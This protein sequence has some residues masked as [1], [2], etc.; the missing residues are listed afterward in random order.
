MKSLSLLISA[1]SL[2]MATLIA[3]PAFAVTQEEAEEACLSKADEMMIADDKYDDFV[4]ECIVK[5]APTSAE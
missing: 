5:M 4:Q 2:I 3:T 1:A